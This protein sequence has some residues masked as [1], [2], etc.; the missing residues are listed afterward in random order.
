MPK[1]SVIMPAYNAEKYIAQ[2][3]ESI[4]G[5]T[6]GDFELIVLNDCSKDKTGEI[7]ASFADQRIVCVNN[8]ENMG[9]A[10]TLNKGLKIARGEYIARMDADDISLPERLEKQAA[11]LDTNE[12]AAVVGSAVER[13]DE[14]GSLGKRVFAADPRQMDIEM[15]FA[16]GLAHPSVMMRRTLVTG[17]GG[18]DADY[19]GLEDYELWWRVSRS[20]Q[21][22]A[23]PEVLLRYRIHS[24]Q[25]TKNPSEKYIKRHRALKQRQ[26]EALGP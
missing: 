12:A 16:C 7:I 17:L 3:I 23:L 6:F 11:F 10:R 24:A 4:L 22:T 14:T 18:Y 25:V 2:A 20:H 13:F 26:L 19:E 8:E 9:V 15:L 1:I 5:Q 21:V